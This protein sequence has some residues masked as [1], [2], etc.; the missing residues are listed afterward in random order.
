MNDFDGRD[1]YNLK[2]NIDNL[3]EANHKGFG[4]REIHIE[5]LPLEPVE[6]TDRQE[7]EEM[8][9]AINI[10]CCLFIGGGFMLFMVAF[11]PNVPFFVRLLC[12]GVGILFFFSGW[13]GLISK[14]EELTYAKYGAVVDRHMIISSHDN[15]QERKTCF[16][17][18]FPESGA[19]INE[20][21][22]TPNDYDEA[23]KGQK[24]LVFA[25]KGYP[26]YAVLCK[27]K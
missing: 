22:C 2:R 8:R 4:Y 11:A 13:R 10:S 7:I 3:K 5:D 9:K 16:D 23:R 24:V 12:A 25:F 18:A 1:F 6:D 14:D 21:R 19:R 17:V 20:I 27:G 26:A 15:S